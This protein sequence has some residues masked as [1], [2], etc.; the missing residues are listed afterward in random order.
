MI[1]AS[2]ARVTTF[3]HFLIL[4][5]SRI[6]SLLIRLNWVYS[7]HVIRQI[8][9]YKWFLVN[10]IAVTFPNYILSNFDYLSIEDNQKLKIYELLIN[11]IKKKNFFYKPPLYLEVNYNTLTCFIIRKFL[12]RTMFDILLY[13]RVNPYFI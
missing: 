6:D 5:E 1:K 3:N 2:S 8:L 12:S 7:K 10:D 11:K 9:R 13:L 4:L